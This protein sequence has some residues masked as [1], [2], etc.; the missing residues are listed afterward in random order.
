MIIFPSKT[1]LQRLSVIVKSRREDI[2]MSQVE[3]AKG[4][5]TQTTIST[6]ENKGCFKSWDLVPKIFEKLNLDLDDLETECNYRYGEIILKQVERNLIMQNF[7]K[8]QKRLNKIKHENLDTKNLLARYECSSGFIDLFVNGNQDDAISNFTLAI[9]QHQTRDNQI[10]IGWAYLGIAIAYRQLNL[11]KQTKYYLNLAIK[12]LHLCLRRK[13]KPTEF[14]QM[15]RFAMTLLVIV[16]KTNDLELCLS[17]SRVV[18]KKLKQSHSF[19][20][21]SDFYKLKGECFLKNNQKEKAAEYFSQ[22]EKLQGLYSYSNF[23][24]LNLL[25]N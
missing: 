20:C 25:F 13:F 14:R 6:L 16:A 17:E 7:G 24:K 12:E 19:Y 15:I 11:N 10:I 9:N 1:M 4:I 21:L 23:K 18:V 8:A 5:C 22:A 2:H 3:L